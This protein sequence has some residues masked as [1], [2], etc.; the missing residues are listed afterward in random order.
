[1]HLPRHNIS[2]YWAIL[3]VTI[4]ATSSTLLILNTIQAISSEYTDVVFVS[5]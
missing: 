4:I 1:M 2:V 5:E 3:L